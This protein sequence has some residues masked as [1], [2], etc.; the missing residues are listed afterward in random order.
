MTK[1]VNGFETVDVL[2]IECVAN[3]TH[4][5]AMAMGAIFRSIARLTDDREIKALCEHGALQA[6]L[7][8]NDI[9]VLRERAVKAGL[10]AKPAKKEVA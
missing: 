7:Q 9:D 10:E 6:D 5:Q 2:T 1:L 4:E 8:G 3:I